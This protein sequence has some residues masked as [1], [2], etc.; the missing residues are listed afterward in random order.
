MNTLR[1]CN[2]L[3]S[4]NIELIKKTAVRNCH[5]FGLNSFII[6]E[7]PRIRLF[8][9]EPDCELFQEFDYKNPIIPIHPHK[10][11]DIFSQLEGVMINHIYKVAESG[12]KFNSYKYN[13]LSNNKSILELAGTETLSYVGGN[14]NTTF[15]TSKQ[16][17]TASLEGDRCSWTITETFEDKNFIQVAYHQNLLEREGLYIPM[18]NPDE[19]LNDYFEQMLPKKSYT[20]FTKCRCGRFYGDQEKQ[21]GACLQCRRDIPKNN[22]YNKKYYK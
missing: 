21:F 18:L 6:N 1:L 8:I 20:G 4:E 5:C 22:K 2:Y 16:L 14:R 3:I 13:R 11:D 12:I 15:L 17:H 9:A 10:Y 19:Y 7:K